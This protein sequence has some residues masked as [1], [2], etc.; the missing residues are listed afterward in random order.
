M[1]LGFFFHSRD[2]AI[3]SMLEFLE[4]GGGTRL[5]ELMVLAEEDAN[6]AE[7]SSSSCR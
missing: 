6:A 4:A 2:L 3:L 1:V 7:A 5:A